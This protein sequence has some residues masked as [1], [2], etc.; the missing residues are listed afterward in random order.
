MHIHSIRI[1]RVIITFLGVMICAVQSSTA[2]GISFQLDFDSLQTGASALEGGNYI[3]EGGLTPIPYAALTTTIQTEAAGVSSYCGNNKREGAEA[4]DGN[5]VDGATCQSLGFSQGNLSCSATCT[6]NTTGCF[7][8]GTTSDQGATGGREGGGGHRSLPPTSAQSSQTS[9]LLPH[10]AATASSQSSS[11][12]V[13]QSAAA[14]SSELQHASADTSSVLSHASASS[15]L[16]LNPSSPLSSASSSAATQDHDASK[17]LCS[18]REYTGSSGDAS[19]LYAGAGEQSAMS[20]FRMAIDEVSILLHFPV[21]PALG[22]LLIAVLPLLITVFR[23][24]W[25]LL[26]R[27]RRK[28]KYKSSHSKRS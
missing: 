10:G 7:S 27:H 16:P 1:G 5:D 21:A 28:P 3:L 26:L 14:S 22:G 20:R 6:L 2:Y 19:T 8:G 12:T 25:L 15:L 18:T 4:C 23:F 13:S 11:R 9:P 17:G 24:R